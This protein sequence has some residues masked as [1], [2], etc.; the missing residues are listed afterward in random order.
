MSKIHAAT[1]SQQ[2]RLKILSGP[3]PTSLGPRISPNVSAGGKTNS[4][5]STARV[6]DVINHDGIEASEPCNHL[7]KLQ[8][9][10]GGQK[11]VDQLEGRH[12]EDPEL[13]AADPLPADRG[14]EVGLATTGQGHL[15]APTWFH[16]W[17]AP[18]Y[19]YP[20]RS[21]VPVVESTDWIVI[22]S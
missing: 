15:S 10:L 18:I 22:L 13:V 17:F 21:L 11:L 9:A 5:T 14:R 20:K 16:W 19:T 1:I 12:E 6:A 8:V 2:S 3:N 7:R 4:A